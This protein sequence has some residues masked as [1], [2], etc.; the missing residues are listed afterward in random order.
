M[1]Y[2]K[3]TY[4]DVCG[5]RTDKLPYILTL[6][7]EYKKSY[8]KRTVF[9]KRLCE[10]CGRKMSGLKFTGEKIQEAIESKIDEIKL[11]QP[12]GMKLLQ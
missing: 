9:G 4:C 3:I 8:S 2:T 7:R 1:G 11:N 12:K 5:K 6:M 10:P